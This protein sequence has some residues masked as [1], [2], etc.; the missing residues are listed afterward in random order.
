MENRA[1]EAKSM[2][3]VRNV[4]CCCLAFLLCIIFPYSITTGKSQVA[5]CESLLKY[6]YDKY[7][8]LHIWEKFPK[9]RIGND[10]P[11]RD[12]LLTVAAPLSEKMWIFLNR[13]P[14]G[15]DI[16]T[17]PAFSIGVRSVRDE[18]GLVGDKS[19]Y[20]PVSE[21]LSISL[22]LGN[23][24]K[25]NKAASQYLNSRVATGAKIITSFVYNAPNSSNKVAY[26]SPILG[27]I[28][29]DK[30]NIST[31]D[32][33]ASFFE[34][35]TNIRIE[36]NWFIARQFSEEYASGCLNEAK[37]SCRLLLLGRALYDHAN[38]LKQDARSD[39]TQKL[40]AY[41]EK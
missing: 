31:N 20:V 28:D 36:D 14:S 6:S 38:D 7:R 2:S 15:A 1:G 5:P 12:Y 21:L 18:S 4:V 24:E 30:I 22:D 26:M 32:L 39:V 33:A 37:S 19:F 16:E 40:C 10:D 13:L 8:G 41:I 9:I 17:P 3:I 35:F 23:R 25:V 34:L 11:L 27:N 29:L